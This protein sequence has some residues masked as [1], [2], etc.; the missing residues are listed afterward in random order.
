V[1]RHKLLKYG[2][3]AVRPESESANEHA[4][5]LRFGQTIEQTKAFFKSTHLPNVLFIRYK[6][7]TFLIALGQQ[8]SGESDGI[9]DRDLCEFL[10]R[11]PQDLRVLRGKSLVRH[12]YVLLISW[13][14]S[15]RFR[16]SPRTSS[17]T[18][19]K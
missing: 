16:F 17:S 8:F 2:F 10:R 18:S 1:L 7:D 3:S 13:D 4:M 19:E 9:R 15:S 6:I 14:V 11:I 12:D 5:P